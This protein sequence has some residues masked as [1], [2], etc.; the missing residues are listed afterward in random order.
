MAYPDYNVPYG[1]Q[2]LYV[3]TPQYHYRYAN[4]AIYQV[5]PTNQVILALAALISGDRFAVGQPL[6]VGYDM[7]NVPF[8]YRDRYADSD[9]DW[10]RYADGTIYRVDPGSGLIE[11]AI[12]VYA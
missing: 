11:E 2:S 8:D 5:D 6:P 3:D 12:P 7:Y 1:Y 10:Y 9:D 4:D